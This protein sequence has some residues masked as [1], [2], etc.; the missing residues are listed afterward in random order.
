MILDMNINNSCDIG[1]HIKNI[2][3]LLAD[4]LDSGLNMAENHLT[5]K[6]TMAYTIE[7]LSIKVRL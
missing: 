2:F 4:A 6:T 3:T 7:K 5:S 1:S